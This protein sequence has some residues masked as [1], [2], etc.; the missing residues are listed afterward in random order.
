MTIKSKMISKL[1]RE[2]RELEKHKIT[3]QPKCNYCG[4]TGKIEEYDQCGIV[5]RESQCQVCDLGW[6]NA[7]I[8]VRQIRLRNEIT[9]IRKAHREA[10]AGTIER[11]KK[12]G[13]PRKPT[14]RKPS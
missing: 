7:G 8:S 9:L 10:M 2:I 3:K 11:Y 1:Q 12:A 14:R 6:I 5:C 4:S 13:Q